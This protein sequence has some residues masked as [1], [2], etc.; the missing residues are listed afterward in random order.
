MITDPILTTR[1]FD[2]EAET[3][4]FVHNHPDRLNDTFENGETLLHM[5]AK[6]GYALLAYYVMSRRSDADFWMSSDGLRVNPADICAAAQN[7]VSVLI[8]MIHFFH[9]KE[10]TKDYARSLREIITQSFTQYDYKRF[11]A[12]EKIAEQYIAGIEPEIQK[13]LNAKPLGVQFY[14]GACRLFIWRSFQLQQSA[15]GITTSLLDK[16]NN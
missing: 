10:K 9:Q 1:H 14:E 7:R 15:E 6:R 2:R 13:I 4:R 11:L 8:V 5:A 3:L 16:K 12:K